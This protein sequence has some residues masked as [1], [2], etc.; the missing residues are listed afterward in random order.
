MPNRRKYGVAFRTC[1]VYMITNTVNGKRYIGSS[2][3]IGSRLSS[4]FGYTSRNPQG[5]PL[6]VDINKYGKD[7]FDHEVLEECDETSK[8]EREQYWVDELKP[9]YNLT[10]PESR[11]FI[12]DTRKNKV[13]HSKKQMDH[14]L[15]NKIHFNTDEGKKVLREANSHKMKPVVLIDKVTD[16]ELM[17]FESLSATARWLDVNTDFKHVNKASEVKFVCDGTRITAYGYKYRYKNEED[18]YVRKVR[19]RKKV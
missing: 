3:C 8:V 19:V 5:R 12:S 10:Q 4:H 13:K 17:E 6:H 7:V 18:K 1:G 15:R 11:E 16:E 2:A 14:Y 9:E